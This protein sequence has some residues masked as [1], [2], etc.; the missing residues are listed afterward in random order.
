MIKVCGL[1]DCKNIE[2]VDQL[3]V[4]LLGFIY[5]DKSPRNVPQSVVLPCSKAKKV[6]VFVNEESGKILDVAKRNDLSYVQLH[7]NEQLDQIIDLKYSGLNVIK[8]ISIASKLDLE[9]AR[10]F[11]GVADIILL[12]TKGSKEGGN[13]VKFDWRIID[14]Y[15]LDCP[16]MLSGGIGVSDA[17]L[18]RGIKHPKFLGVDINS[19]FEIEPAIKDVIKIKKFINKIIK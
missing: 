11:D 7:G 12:D 8:A 6:G 5:Y 3:G 9:Q 18:V 15:N 10:V 13:G 16:F 14:Y 17:E 4:D 1:R 19:R 2:E